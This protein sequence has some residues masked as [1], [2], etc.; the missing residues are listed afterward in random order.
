M[1]EDEHGLYIRYDELKTWL[2]AFRAK[3]LAVPTAKGGVQ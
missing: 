3:L 2:D 1:V